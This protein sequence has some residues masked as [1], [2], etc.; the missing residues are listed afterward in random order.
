MLRRD[1]GGNIIATRINK[2][3][4]VGGGDMFK[5][6]SKFGQVAHQFR[7]CLL[8]KHRLTVKY[9]DMRI[10]HLAMDEQRHAN[11]RHMFKRRHDVCHIGDAMRASGGCVRWV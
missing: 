9:V 10:G 2:C 6:Y 8:Y 4:R 5:D 1:G 7:K 11:A 3:D